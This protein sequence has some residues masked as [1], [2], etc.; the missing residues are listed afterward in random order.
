MRQG[1]TIL[2]YI[3]QLG[4]PV[5]TT[6][7]L[8]AVSGK[9]L[10]TTTQALNHLQQQGIIFKIYRGI[11]GESDSGRISPYAVIS[12]LFP[13][14]RAYVSFISALHLYGMIEQ[15][16]QV[17]TLASTAHTR[18]IRTTVG[19]FSVHR[20]ESSFFAGFTWYKETGDFLIALP[21][22]ALVDSLYL[23]ARKKKQ[24][25]YFPE[26]HFCKPFS[27]TKAQQWVG[28]IPDIKIRRYVQRRLDEIIWLKNRYSE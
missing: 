20:I 7:E 23:S 25:G 22:K 14:Q 3:K 10:S 13:R 4:R 15:I 5:F 27:F 1:R 2:T 28:R 12:F 19:T 11:W 21:E 9:S 8:S 17:I 16:P 6:Y 26:L 24:F 18:I